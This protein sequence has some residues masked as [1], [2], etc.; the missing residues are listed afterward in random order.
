MYDRNRYRGR[1]ERHRR[2]ERRRRYSSSS[3]SDRQRRPRT[4]KRFRS[5]SNSHDEC[6]RDRRRSPRD[7]KQRSDSSSSFVKE[8]PN[9]TPSGILAEYQNKVN[10]VALKFSTP[11]DACPP[12]DIYSLYR[13]SGDKISQTYTLQTRDNSA[14]AF[15][16]GTDEAVCHIVLESEPYE[17]TL[18]SK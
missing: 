10:G 8:E 11:Q 6:R 3:E 12:T 9:F 17:E 13:F 15:L 7:N 4:N 16:I 14:S 18:V 2:D 1:D 5:R